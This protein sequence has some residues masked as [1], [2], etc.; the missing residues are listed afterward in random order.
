MSRSGYSDDCDEG[1]TLYRG[2]VHSAM[3]GKR[4]R[5]FLAEMAAALDALPEKRLIANDFVQPVSGLPFA[6]KGG[7]V[8]AM[9]AVAVARGMSD[10]ADIDPEYIEAVAVKMGIADC[11]AREIAFENDE[12]VCR[13]ETPEQRWQRMRKWIDGWLAV[14]PIVRKSKTA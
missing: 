3:R 14:G 2:R 11:M 4:G 8:C 13:P 1:A 9:G 5:A 7:E 6:P 10:A 12:A